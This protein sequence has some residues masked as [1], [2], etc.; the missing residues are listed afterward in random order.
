MLDLGASQHLFYRLVRADATIV[1]P[2]SLALLTRRI[3]CD[4]WGEA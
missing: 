3:D 4:G 1:A 2:G